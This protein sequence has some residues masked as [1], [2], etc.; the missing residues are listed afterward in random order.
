MEVIILAGG[1]GTRLRGVIPDYL[2]KPMASIQGK[3]FLE[4][5][6]NRLAEQGVTSIILAV[7]HLH[8]IICE[9]FGTSYRGL[10]IQY[11]V[12]NEPLGT[13]GALLH[14]LSLVKGQGAFFVMN[15]D[16][17]FDFDMQSIYQSY[18]H[19]SLSIGVSHVQD[20]S[21]YGEVVLK[22]ERIVNFIHRGTNREGYVNAGIYLMTKEA[23]HEKRKGN[24]F[25]WEKDFLQKKVHILKPSYFILNKG[26]YDI[27]TRESYIGLDNDKIF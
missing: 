4:H 25:S 22:N 24:S 26:F 27:G 12:E 9:H 10:P 20:T 15:G 11:A 14:A 17:F 16:T 19:S 18:R 5:M 2:P 7:H 6:F 1:F 3:P 8:H 23:L 21:R 13:G